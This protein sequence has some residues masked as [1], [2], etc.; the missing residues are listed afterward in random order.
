MEYPVDAIADSQIALGRLD[1][2]VGG[3]LLHRLQDDQVD[4]LHDRGLL[5][6]GA[7]RG[8]VLLLVEG[9]VDHDLGDVVDLL[10]E[11]AALVEQIGQ[12]GGGDG[13]AGES[14]AEQGAQVVDCPQISRCDH[15]DDQFT[16]LTAQWHGL[17]PVAEVLGQQRPQRRIADLDARLSIGGRRHGRRE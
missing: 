3:S 11:L 9:I 8:E 4:E 10:V 14:L 15:A 7:Q 5:D 6:D 16:V 12:L 2:D 13:D 1:V 17:V